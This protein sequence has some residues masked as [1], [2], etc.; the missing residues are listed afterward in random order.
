MITKVEI[1]RLAESC[2]KG[3]AQ[4]VETIFVDDKQVSRVLRGSP[5][6]TATV[7]RREEVITFEAKSVTRRRP[8]T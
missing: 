8:T 5:A 2:G 4:L 1:E 3:R 7:R 6:P